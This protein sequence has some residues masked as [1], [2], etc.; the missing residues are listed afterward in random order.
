MKKITFLHF[1]A[2]LLVIVIGFSLGLPTEDEDEQTLTATQHETKC[3]AL[4]ATTGAD[5]NLI[6]FGGRDCGNKPTASAFAWAEN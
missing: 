1:S 6:S 2:G 5:I 4:A 3:V